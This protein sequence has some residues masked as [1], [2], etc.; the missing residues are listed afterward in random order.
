M[1]RVICF[2]GGKDSMALWLWARRK[3]LE[4][5]RVVFC[6]TG[7]EHHLT[8]GYIEA[9]EKWM[10]EKVERLR[11]KET[12]DERVERLRGFPSSGRR[13]GLADLFRDERGVEWRLAPLGTA[14]YPGKG[15]WQ[16][17]VRSVFRKVWE[18]TR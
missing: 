16:G 10:V 8:L 18:S 9:A 11:G 7:W 4:P 6:D 17:G 1:I 3:G 2:S 14:L 5:H 13:C 12:F 15:S